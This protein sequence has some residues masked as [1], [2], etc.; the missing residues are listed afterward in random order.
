M[1]DSSHYTH[2]VISFALIQISLNKPRNS[3]KNEPVIAVEV[4][5][6]ETL[7]MS[8][9][10]VGAHSSFIKYHASVQILSVSVMSK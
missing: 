10:Y 3:M 6:V 4:A 9:Q 1:S 8:D 5:V 7:L 2:S